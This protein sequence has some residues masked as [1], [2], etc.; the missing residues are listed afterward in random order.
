[1]K[2][3]YNDISCISTIRNNERYYNLTKVLID[4]SSKRDVNDITR[5]KYWKDFIKAIKYEFKYDVSNNKFI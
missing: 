3:S 1:M 2:T 4:N 5:N